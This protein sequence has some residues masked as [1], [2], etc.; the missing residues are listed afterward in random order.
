MVTK[1]KATKKAG[2]TKAAPA[3]ILRWNPGRKGDP[4]PPFFNKLNQ[5]AQKQ[6]VAFVNKVASIAARGR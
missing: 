2:K 1:K 4:P 6:F 5:V 3:A